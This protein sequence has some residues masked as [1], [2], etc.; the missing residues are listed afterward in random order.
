MDYKKLRFETRQIHAGLDHNPETGARG[1]AIYPTAA[2][3]FKTCD[4][5]AKLFELSEGGNIY[6][7]LQNPTT[8][9][10]EER[11]AALYGAVGALGVA[12]GMSAIL[13][14]VTALASE[15]DNIVASPFLYGGTYNQFRHTLRRLGIEV[16]IATT[17]TPEDFAKLIDIRTRAL[18]AESMGNPTCAVLDLEGLG[19]VARENKVPLIIDNTFGAAG[20]LCNPFDWG[21]NIVVDSATKWIN[22]HGTAMGGIIVDG[23]NFDW[24]CG[25][26]PGIDGPS[27]GYHGLNFYEAFGPA[28][29]IVK[30]RV[31][32]LRDMGACPS[33]FDSYLMML[34]LETLSL[35][36]RHE[37]EA[38]R[39]LAEY[40][41]D[42]PKVKNISYV[43]FPDHPGHENAAK[44]FRFGASAVLNVELK[45][46]LESTVKFVEAL[47]LAAHMTMIGDSITVVTHPASTTHKQLS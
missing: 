25:K 30:C 35:R 7:R 15:G 18:F 22:G 20:Y 33:P 43:G 11:I 40:L 12:S 2:Y 24:S 4:Y 21:A 32:G 26:F 27:E 10:Y 45:G 16:R 34:G 31:D 3:R 41:K 9:A 13:I 8:S 6:T 14:A 17:E 28:A 37:V 5:A 39:R 1:V 38:T 29:F 19:R 46:T 44:Y 36:V 42:H 23:G 47:Q